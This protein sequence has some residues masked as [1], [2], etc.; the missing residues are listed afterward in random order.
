MLD[1]CASPL[2]TDITNLAGT[3]GELILLHGNLLRARLLVNLVAQL[4]AKHL[5]NI[6]LLAFDPSLCDVL[7]QSGTDVACAVCA[8]GPWE[9]V[10][11]GP[12]CAPWGRRYPVDAKYIAWMRRLHLLRKLA[13]ARLNVLAIDSDVAV[14]AD[15]YPMLAALRRAS[16]AVSLL[17]TYDHVVGFAH[18]NIGVLHLRGRDLATAGPTIGLLRAV[19]NRVLDLLRMPPPKTR[20]EYDQRL[21]GVWDQNAFNKQVLDSLSWDERVQRSGYKSYMEAARRMFK[22]KISMDD[23]WLSSLGWEKTLVPAPAPLGA[24]SPWYPPSAPLY[25]RRLLPQKTANPDERLATA[26]QWFVSMENGLGLRWRHFLY[27][28]SPPPAAFLHFTC[29]EKT[30]SARAWPLRVFGAWH[31]QAIDAVQPHILKAAPKAAMTAAM[32]VQDRFASLPANGSRPSASTALLALEGDAS[33][34]IP[35]LAVTNALHAALGA[36]ALRFG[37][38]AVLPAFNCSR[39]TFDFGAQVN[40]PDQVNTNDP[41]TATNVPS[42]CFWHFRDGHK[43]RRCVYRLGWCPDAWLATASELD[44]AITAMRPMVPP[45]VQLDLRG[46]VADP[47]GGGERLEAALRE[48]DAAS[49]A[50]VVLL[51]LRLPTPTGVAAAEPAY[52]NRVNKPG[53]R[54]K[55]KNCVAD[56]GPHVDAVGERFRSASDEWLARA[57]K[58]FEAK[59]SDLTSRTPRKPCVTQCGS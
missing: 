37:R 59:C 1:A 12:P 9:C 49:G 4:H 55:P 26:P 50:P 10:H 54:H 40:E 2:P 5:R 21:G 43:R 20:R 39:G 13:E 36:L 46:G 29:V 18:L 31:A 27:G 44:V 35:S 30:E 23:A 38:R 24:F 22:E 34:S 28:E 15:P 11:D 41:E 3:S 6:L 58:R 53:A 47:Y 19:E 17:L 25:W 7:Q 16:P 51:R 48:M 56:R 14:M 32:R 45:L 57:W 33:L 42:R 8:S 52:C